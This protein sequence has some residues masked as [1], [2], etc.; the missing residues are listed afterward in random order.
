MKEIK[1]KRYNNIEEMNYN[2]NVLI[3]YKNKVNISSDIFKS[4]DSFASYASLIMEIDPV[5]GHKEIR[6][7]YWALRRLISKKFKDV[8]EN[9]GE[10]YI[11]K[12]LRYYVITEYIKIAS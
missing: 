5:L 6:R 3:Y 12:A 2:Y 1:I 9:E 8:Y 10:E 11:I 7:S 4:L